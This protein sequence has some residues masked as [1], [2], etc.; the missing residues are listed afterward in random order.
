MTITCGMSAFRPPT[1][2]PAP[3]ALSD[4]ESAARSS[5][6]QAGISPGSRGTVGGP[7]DHED[8]A[9]AVSRGGG[10]GGGG[11]FVPPGTRAADS[12]TGGGGGRG[13]GGGDRTGFPLAGLWRSAFI[14]DREG[15]AWRDRDL[16]PPSRADVREQ[17]LPPELPERDGASLHAAT[18]ST[19]SAGSASFAAFAAVPS[20][21][22]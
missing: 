18:G 22:S 6:A 16:L 2:R 17:A 5:L 12:R 9:A 3:S 10:G 15:D 4:G 7:L 19:R 11:C 1:P 13:G 8:L 21:G 20:R 14:G